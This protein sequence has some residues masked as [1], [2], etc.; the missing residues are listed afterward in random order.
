MRSVVEKAFKRHSFQTLAKLNNSRLREEERRKSK[1]IEERLVSLENL[2][3]TLI[4]EIELLK[5]TK[6][7]KD[8][9]KE[10]VESLDKHRAISIYR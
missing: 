2:T 4:S 8:E 1:D 10:V 6:T 7:G 5:A 3:R 9:F